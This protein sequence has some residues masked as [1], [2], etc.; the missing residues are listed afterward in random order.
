MDIQVWADFECPYCMIGKKRLVKALKELGI[1]D[2]QVSVRS[3]LL[4]PEPMGPEGISM[5]E[6]AA[7]KFG[8]GS[9]KLEKVERNFKLL[10]E[11][12]RGLGLIMHIGEARTASAWNAHRLFQFAKTLGLGSRFFDRVQEA[13]F[14]ESLLI[15]DDVVL[16]RLAEDAGLPISKAQE[17]LLDGSRFR[18]AVQADHDLGHSMNIDYIPYYLA[19]G[20]YL[21][22]GDLT[23][24]AYLD[25]LKAVI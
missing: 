22:S 24:Q 21:Y 4:T 10:E 8:S 2:A 15:S 3:Y 18:N 9:D 5:R 23:M 19:D 16:L 14:T 11:E 12:G 17:V 7:N 25:G 20:K 1:T 6:R 13:L